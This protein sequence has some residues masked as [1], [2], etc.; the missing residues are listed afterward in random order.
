VILGIGADL[1]SIERIASSLD[2]F[3]NRFAQR[4]FTPA[5]QGHC[6]G[7]PAA[8]AKRWAAKEACAKALRTG[9]RDDLLMT[10]IAVEN[11][12]LGA[13]S[14][15]LTGGALARLDALT[16][17]GHRAA[18]HLTLTDDPP[19]AQAFVVIEAVEDRP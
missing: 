2:R 5:E 6:R 3:G 18:I 12:A 4:I 13:P 9:F 17:P 11:D 1:C 7:R 10:D 15:R 14:L 16:P 19:W 8:Y